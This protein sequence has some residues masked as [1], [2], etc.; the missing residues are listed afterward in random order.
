MF[1]SLSPCAKQDMDDQSPKAQ[2]IPVTQ[3]VRLIWNQPFR[4]Q[5][6]AVGAL[7]VGKR[8]RLGA[9]VNR[10]MKA[11]DAMFDRSVECQ[12]HIRLL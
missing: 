7:H 1:F 12:I 2:L 4:V 5:I 10:G 11:R 9:T 3:N 6:G 8:N